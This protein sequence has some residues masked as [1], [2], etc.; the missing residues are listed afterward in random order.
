MRLSQNQKKKQR[1]AQ[2]KNIELVDRNLC[3]TSSNLDSPDGVVQPISD[4][5]S[6]Q[7]APQNHNSKEKDSSNKYYNESEQ[8]T[9]E[10][11]KYQV[12]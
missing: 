11:S 1:R 7:Y 9:E 4:A 5:T 3:L 12:V 8:L 2:L 10:K 6:S